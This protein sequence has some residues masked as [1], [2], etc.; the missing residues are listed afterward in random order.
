LA[1]AVIVLSKERAKH[2]YRSRIDAKV[3]PTTITAGGTVTVNAWLSAESRAGTFTRASGRTVQVW[4]KTRGV[5]E[6]TRIWVGRSNASGAF[7]VKAKPTRATCYQARFASN[8]LWESKNTAP[9][10]V[11]VKPAPTP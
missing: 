3:A 6:W 10:C 4:A 8:R 11:S 7:A 1:W 5:G 2:L 9:K